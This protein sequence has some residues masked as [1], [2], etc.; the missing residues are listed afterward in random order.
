[1]HFL[2]VLESGH[3]VI[4]FPMYCARVRENAHSDTD[5]S[6]SFRRAEGVAR[7]AT[8]LAC[9]TMKQT[10]TVDMND[11][12]AGRSIRIRLTVKKFDAVQPALTVEVSRP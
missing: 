11:P 8:V 4:S 2:C 3:V 10:A 9:D 7:P 12:I 6:R 5:H 1:M